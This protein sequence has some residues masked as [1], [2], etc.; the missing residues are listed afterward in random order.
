MFDLEYIV[1]RREE[2]SLSQASMA[3]KMGFSNASVYLKYEK[4]EYKFKADMLPRLAKAL[5]CKVKNFF[6]A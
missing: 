6:T 2:L 1:K 5:K 3:Q 4:G